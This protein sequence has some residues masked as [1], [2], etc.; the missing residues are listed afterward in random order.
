M[1]FKLTRSEENRRDILADKLRDARMI[2][3][4]AVAAQ[5][6]IIEDAYAAINAALVPYNE[7]VEKARGFVEDIASERDSEWDD[8]SER[9][10][11]GERGEA[12]RE[13]ISQWQD[14]ADCEIETVDDVEVVTVDLELGDLAEFL[15]GLPTEAEV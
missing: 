7:I 5:V 1:A 6:A 14:A 3:D 15:E 9:W 10:Q 12:A 4:E 2:L 13:W 11:E 8:K